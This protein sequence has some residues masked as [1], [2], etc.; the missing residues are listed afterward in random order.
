MVDPR[1]PKTHK[2]KESLLTEQVL[3]LARR[4]DAF[5]EGHQFEARDI[6]SILRKLLYDYGTS[7]SLLGQLGFKNKIKYLDSRMH[8]NLHLQSLKGVWP[9]TVVPYRLYNDEDTHEFDDWWNNQRFIILY[10]NVEFSRKELVLEIAN[11]QGGDHIDPNSDKRIAMLNRNQSPWH[12]TS[13]DEKG[14][15][16]EKNSMYGFELASICAIGE[17]LLWSIED[18]KGQANKR[19]H[20]YEFFESQ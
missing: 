9:R 12:T 1:V 13:Y 7:K 11:R 16:I 10:K 4:C 19:M 15:I 14:E 18:D 6:A 17:E 20:N 8:G 2:E 3:M 5:Y